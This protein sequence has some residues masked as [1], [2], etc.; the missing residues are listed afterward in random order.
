MR[1]AICAIGTLRRSVFQEPFSSF[2][3]RM[4]WS[5]NPIEV[6]PKG[7]STRT[8]SNRKRKETQELIQRIPQG[9]TPVLLDP[10]GED[11]SSEALAKRLLHFQQQGQS[12]AFLIG[13]SHGFCHE[14]LTQQGLGKALRLSFG[15]ATWPHL[16]VRVMLMEQLYRAQ[17]VLNNHPYHKGNL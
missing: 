12:P 4:T 11:I 1:I 8:E 2:L 13:G 10:N 16:L 14:T 6:E 15:K 5:I 7:L 17:Q 3:K 9:F